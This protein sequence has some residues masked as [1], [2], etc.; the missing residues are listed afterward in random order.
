LHSHKAATSRTTREPKRM[1]TM[2]RRR[3]LNAS[4]ALGPDAQKT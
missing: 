4:K 3:I 1:S 2:Q